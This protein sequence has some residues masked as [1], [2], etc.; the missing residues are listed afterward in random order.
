MKFL[1]SI[2]FYFIGSFVFAQDK[3]DSAGQRFMLD[4][5]PGITIGEFSDTHL[6]SIHAGVT[7]SNKRFGLLSKLPASKIGFA[8]SLGFHS[9]F[10]SEE[11]VS[12]QPYSYPN[13]NNTTLAP[14]IIYNPC[15]KGF[16]GLMAGPSLNYYSK[17][18]EA[19]LDMAVNLPC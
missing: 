15:K 14:G 10:G 17:E 3:T 16:I 4:A 13:Y 1:L 7:W 19:G 11:E 6:F 9:L 8:A 2:V 5:G 18:F 12:G